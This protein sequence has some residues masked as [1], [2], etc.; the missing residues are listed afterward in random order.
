[1][2]KRMV[3]N[4]SSNN[5]NNSLTLEQPLKDLQK[6][7]NTLFKRFNTNKIK[8]TGEILDYFNDIII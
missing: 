3:M 5:L 2:I 6:H 4:K 1:M 8:S 7:E